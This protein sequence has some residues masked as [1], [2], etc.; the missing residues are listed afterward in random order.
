MSSTVSIAT[1]SRPTSPRRAASRESW[2]IRLGMSN[3]VREARLAVVEQVAEALVG[4]LGGAEAGELAH[5][6]QP[7]AVH[8]RVHAARERELARERR[9]R[10]AW[11]RTSSGPY[12]ALIGSPESVVRSACWGSCLDRAHGMRGPEIVGSPR[13]LTPEHPDSIRA[14]EVRDAARGLR[15]R[16][17][18]STRSAT[19]RGTPLLCSSRASA[20]GRGRVRADVAQPVGVAGGE[21]RGRRAVAE[22]ARAATSA[23]VVQDDDAR[24]VDHA[25]P[26]VEQPPDQVDVLAVAQRLVEAHR[27]ADDQRR[28]RHVRDGA[29]AGPCRAASGAGSRPGCAARP[30][31]RAGR[32]SAPRAARS[33][34]A[35]GACRRPGTRRARCSR[36]RAR[37]CAPRPA[38][39]SARAGR[40][41]VA[42]RRSRPDRR[43][44]VDDDTRG[45]GL[46]G[47][48]PRPP[49]QRSAARE[50]GGSSLTGITTVTSTALRRRA[51][52]REAGVDQ[53][54]AEPR[55]ARAWRCRRAAR[56]ARRDRRRLSRMMRPRAAR[57]RPPA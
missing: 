9:S 4:L 32:R 57:T 44:V 43:A 26:V 11:S 1:P 6:P 41:R 3:A 25:V 8:R 50:A 2:P 55:A 29:V 21:R 40:A 54:L 20:S 24:V 56:G 35:A 18:R 51:R 39:R 31:P 48:R 16:L 12:S 30:P 46:A 15:E 13:Y 34:P 36:A 53:A 22:A 10:V 37:C 42:P 27:G 28:A 19:R 38:R 45:A 47:R 52:V 14:D 17:R 33:S 7:P 5:R 23:L 49:A